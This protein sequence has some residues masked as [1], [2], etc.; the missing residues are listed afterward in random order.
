MFLDSSIFPKELYWS[1]YYW[2]FKI[3][4]LTFLAL[5]FCQI[6]FSGFSPEPTSIRGYLNHL[7]STQSLGPVTP[8]GDPWTCSGDR[9]APSGR[10]A[11]SAVQ[12]LFQMRCPFCFPVA[13]STSLLAPGLSLYSLPNV[14]PYRVPQFQ[15]VFIRHPPKLLGKEQMWRWLQNEDETPAFCVYFKEKSA[16]NSAVSEWW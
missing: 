14:K 6:I 4:F 11:V 9:W 12:P 16:S 3:M 13:S 7:G 1:F 5:P 8:W 2:T 10:V 15:S